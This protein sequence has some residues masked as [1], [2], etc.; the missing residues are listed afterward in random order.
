MKT[1]KTIILLVAVLVTVTFSSCKKRCSDTYDCDQ[2]NQNGNYQQSII[3][4][5][6]NTYTNTTNVTNNT[7]VDN[8]T[9]IT[10]ST[11]T[12]ISNP[13]MVTGVFKLIDRIG[14]TCWILLSNPGA[15]PNH[16][17]EIVLC[18]PLRVKVTGA[19]S[20]TSIGT[21]NDFTSV[22]GMQAYIPDNI[23]VKGDVYEICRPGTLTAFGV[24]VSTH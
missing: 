19:S 24:N 10:D 21:N 23:F 2:Q 13:G 14:D 1:T 3:G 18:N 20:Y 8:H 5:S 15:N 16:M 17:G 4:N 11:V 12:H 9:T 6:S 7:T 22:T